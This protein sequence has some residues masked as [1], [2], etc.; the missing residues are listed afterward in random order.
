MPLQIL[1][2][3]LP[4]TEGALC[5]ADCGCVVID[6]LRFTTTAAQALNV[7]ARSIQ[8]VS[9]VDDAYSA[10]SSGDPLL[11]RLLCGERHCVP[12]AGFDLGNSP[13]EYRRL[14]VA[15]RE[16]IF[17]TTNGTRAVR[18]LGAFQIC[19]LAALVNRLAVAA[20]IA[21]STIP[22]WKII[23]AG[24]DGQIAG[25]DI[26]AAGALIDGLVELTGDQSLPAD[27]SSL[28]AWSLWKQAAGHADELLPEQLF[29][30]MEK[31]A[32]ARNLLD[33]GYREDIV[34]A[35]RLDSI[36]KVPICQSSQLIFR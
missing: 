19:L 18:S 4:S 15:D 30:T 24:T 28:I 34:F 2:D 9:D 8:I 7:G 12:I 20:L 16:L 23:C 11:P 35:S 29:S 31:F 32:G 13:L 33:A 25:E 26:L 3:M 17:T 21:E 5:H 10:A 1:V 22:L 14:N 6:T 27:D 36:I